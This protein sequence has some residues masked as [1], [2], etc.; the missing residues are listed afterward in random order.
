MA[1]LA[2]YSPARFINVYIVMEYLWQLGVPS[3]NCTIM[4][5]K[6]YD[7]NMSVQLA[8]LEVKR[9]N[10]GRLQEPVSHFVQPNILYSFQPNVP[11]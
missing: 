3:A 6:M 9:Y 7:W 1:S 11:I 4:C 10:C 2:S 5:M 8:S